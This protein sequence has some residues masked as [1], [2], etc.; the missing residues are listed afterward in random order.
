MEEISTDLDQ[1]R[2]VWTNMGQIIRML[3][4]L[5]NNGEDSTLGEFFLFNILH[6]LHV[7]TLYADL[8]LIISPL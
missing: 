5:L 7:F 6:I 2:L 8:P 4:D 3:Q 1:G